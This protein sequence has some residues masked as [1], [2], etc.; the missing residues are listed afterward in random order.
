MKRITEKNPWW[1]DEAFWTAE[2]EPSEEEIDAVYRRLMQYEDTE[3][4]PEHFEH[5]YRIFERAW[6]S[7]ANLMAYEATGFAPEEVQRLADAKRDGRLIILPAGH[8]CE[9]ECR[10]CDYYGACGYL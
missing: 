3:C 7:Q 9:D 8:G 10:D 2:C 5:M 1:I 6:Y 4:S